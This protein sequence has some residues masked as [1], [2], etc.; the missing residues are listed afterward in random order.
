LIVTGNRDDPGNLLVLDGDA[1]DA[2]AH[3]P[4]AIGKL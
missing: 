2:A 4:L 3:D 1:I